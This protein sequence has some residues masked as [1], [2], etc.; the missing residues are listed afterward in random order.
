MSL[1]PEA[2]SPQG[3]AGYA[4]NRV[5][6][7]ALGPHWRKGAGPAYLLLDCLVALLQPAPPPSHVLPAEDRH[8]WRPRGATRARAMIGSQYPSQMWPVGWGIKGRFPTPSR[9]DS[10]PPFQLRQARA[11]LPFPRGT[12]A[13]H[14]SHGEN[15]GPNAQRTG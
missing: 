14:P 6:G 1:V 3:S 15:S 8:I 4:R 2:R 11:G 5:Q 7:G 9:C 13:Q 10:T 12:L